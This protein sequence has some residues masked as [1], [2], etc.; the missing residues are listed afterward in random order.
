MFD[1]RG[2]RKFLMIVQ[3][4][5]APNYV[6]PPTPRRGLWSIITG[7]AIAAFVSEI[8]KDFMHGDDH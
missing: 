2:G 5:P 4:P 6:Q 3:P 1:K 8:L 7:S